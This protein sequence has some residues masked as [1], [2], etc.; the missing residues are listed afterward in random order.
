MRTIA[1]GL[2]ALGLAL[3]VT[4]ASPAGGDDK[5]IAAIVDKAIAAHGFK[6]KD[7]KTLCFTTKSKGTVHLQGMDIA[8]TQDTTVKIPGK[9]REVT[10]LTFDNQKLPPFIVTFDGKSG[11]L[12]ADGQDMEIDDA[13]LADFKEAAHAMQLSQVVFLKDKSLGFAHLG[14]AKVNGKDT[15]GVKVTKKGMKDLDF[16][17]DKST[18]LLAK[19]VR[20]SRNPVTA[21]EV[22][23]ERIITQYHDVDGRKFPKKAEV[24]HDGQPFVE[25]EVI[26]TRVLD[27]VEDSVFTKKK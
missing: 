3:A 17:F 2:V 23:E 24:K 16:Y 18:G 25:V 9:Y 7:A 11:T 4:S 1:L 27:N 8:F 15:V 10:E 5:A 13:K 22:N 26:E 6:E 12:S 21:E 14:D 20:R 19:T